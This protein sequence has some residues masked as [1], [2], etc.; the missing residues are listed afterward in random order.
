MKVFLSWSGPTSHKVAIVFRD[1]LSNVIQSIEPYVSSEDIDKGARWSTDIA[2]ELSDSK[3]GILCV[4]KDN[5]NAPWLIFEA[6][7]LSK[8]MDK[9]YVT[10]FLFDIKQSEIDGPILQFQSTKFNK[11]DILKLVKTINKASDNAPLTEDKLSAAFDRW[12]PNLEEELNKVTNNESTT[13]N[14]PV[15]NDVKVPQSN[16]IM[17]DV[18]ELTRM[19]QKILRNVDSSHSESISILDKKIS[20]IGDQFKNLKHYLDR[21]KHRRLHPRMIEELLHVGRDKNRYLVVKVILGT[22]KDDFPWIYESGI[23]L[24]NTLKQSNMK[25]EKRRAMT[26]FRELLEFSFEH[27]IMRD[28]SNSRY[29]HSEDMMMLRELPHF[30]MRTFEVE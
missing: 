1:W 2:T 17:E 6:G 23:E 28:I 9:T 7:A 14:D 22:I 20:E 29:H 30:L 18:L 4:T 15:E 5:V 26:E 11:A 12:Y 19:N 10:P 24:I 21:K 27:P 16:E 13:S 8:T 3:F 25:E